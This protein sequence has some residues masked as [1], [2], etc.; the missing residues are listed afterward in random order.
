MHMGYLY[1]A[2]SKHCVVAF[3]ASEWKQRFFFIFRQ[4]EFYNNQHAFNTV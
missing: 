3:E 1:L 4:T 2:F